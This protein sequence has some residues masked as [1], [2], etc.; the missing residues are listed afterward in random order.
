MRKIF[1]SILILSF[2]IVEIG[3][4]AQNDELPSPGITP[5]SPFYFLKSWKESIQTFFTFGAENKAKQFL[6]LAE[7]RLAEYQKMIEKGKTEIAEKTLEKYGRQLNQALEKTEEAKEKGKDVEELAILITE[8]TLKH[9]EVLVD[10][11]EEVPEEAKD[12]IQKAIEV[13]RKGSEE[14]VKAVNGEKKE[15]LEKK[16]QELKKAEI[17]KKIEEKPEVPKVEEVPKAEEKPKPKTE[18]KLFENTPKSC[19]DNSCSSYRDECIRWNKTDTECYEYRKI[20]HADSCK[21]YKAYCNL[22]IVNNE[23]EKTIN[24]SFDANYMTKDGERHFV[25]KITQ[26]ILAGHG[27]S[28]SWTYDVPA[29]QLGRCDY[30]NLTEK[31][32]SEE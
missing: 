22:V 16:A 4:L 6:H 23:Q 8:K 31:P 21:Q 17:K 9:Q 20:C 2:L 10:V 12:A 14:A 27:N 5:D 29:G 28:I 13:S 25:E 1:F 7:V 11:F 15:E 32:A 26:T 3:V 19:L 24:F 18:V 30:N